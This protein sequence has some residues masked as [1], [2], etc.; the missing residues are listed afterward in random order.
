MC[1]YFFTLLLS[2]VVRAVRARKRPKLFVVWIDI[3]HVKYLF[4][5][6]GKCV[7][8]VYYVQRIRLK[9]IIDSY[10]VLIIIID[11]LRRRHRRRD[12]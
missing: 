8:N 6:D 3:F 9:I 1:V 4:D 2:F 11:I 10:P 7:Y 5:L 12:H